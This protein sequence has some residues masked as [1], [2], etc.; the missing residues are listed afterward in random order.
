MK[1]NTIHNPLAIGITG[2]IGSGK[3]EVCKIF[4][5]HGASVLYADVIA[6][7]LIDTDPLIKKRIQRAFGADIYLPDGTLNR[8]QMARLAFSDDSLKEKLN[9]IVHPSVLEYLE[10][11]IKQFKKNNLCYSCTAF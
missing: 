1:K 3:S 4:S 8:K 9:A 5:S 11:K 7:E 10:S 6:R 2:G